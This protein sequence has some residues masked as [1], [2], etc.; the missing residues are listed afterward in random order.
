MDDPLVLDDESLLRRCFDDNASGAELLVEVDDAGAI[1]RCETRNAND[2]AVG[3][4]CEALLATGLVAEGLRGTR[5]LAG[6]SFRPADRVS[7]ANA[8][9]SAS[10]RA[11]YEPYQTSAGQERWRQ[12]VSDPSIDGWDAPP[13][14][15]LAD[16]FLEHEALETL[17]LTGTVHFGPTGEPTEVRVRSGAEHLAGS[18]LSC[19]LAAMSR[20]KAPCPVQAE[21]A[22][23]WSASVAFRV[24]GS[25]PE[26]SGL[27]GLLDP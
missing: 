7:P 24:I 10:V 5:A 22:A 9:I 19:V 23:A 14:V 1:G 20:S 3:C 21:T 12:V 26:S 17:E 11:A 6:I 18:E 25:G 27:E 16:C 8:V 2:P 4:A 15:E 13:S